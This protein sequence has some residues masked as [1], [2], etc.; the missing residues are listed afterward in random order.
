[1][2]LADRVI[3]IEDGYIALDQRIN[4][5]RP[6]QPGDVRFAVLERQILQRV[7]KRPGDAVAE[8]PNPLAGRVNAKAH[9]L[10]RAV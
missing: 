4:L 10:R 9:S 2:L 5:P 6:R 7:L 3:L 8:R 1:M